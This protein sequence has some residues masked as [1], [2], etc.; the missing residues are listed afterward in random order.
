[1]FPN[2]PHPVYLTQRDSLQLPADVARMLMAGPISMSTC[3]ETATGRTAIPPMDAA[4]AMP[5]HD[6]SLCNL[7]GMGGD[8]LFVPFV[9]KMFALGDPMGVPATILLGVLIIWMMVVMGHNLQVPPSV[10]PSRVRSISLTL[11]LQVVLGDAITA[12][13]EQVTDAW[14]AQPKRSLQTVQVDS[15]SKAQKLQDK[16]PVA[17]EESHR[18][19]VCY[20]HAAAD[21]DLFY[22]TQQ[23]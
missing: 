11:M 22:C 9:S 1:M 15:G 3:P 10:C 4:Q 5:F 20:L 21:H 23:Q 14:A 19:L 16:V 2:Y 13:E 6:V 17:A 8:Y 7:M 12:Y 18:C